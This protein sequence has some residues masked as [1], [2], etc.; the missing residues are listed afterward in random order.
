VSYSAESVAN[1]FLFLSKRDG[2]VVTNMQLQKL[3]Y[4]AH[5]YSLALM[6][7]PLINNDVHAFQYGPVYP[8]LYKKLSLYGS[9]DVRESVKSED[10][11]DP[12]SQEFDLIEAV[13]D[14]YGKMSGAKLS[15]LTH[16]DDTP[17]HKI[18]HTKQFAIIPNDLIKTH[19]QAK[20]AGE[21]NVGE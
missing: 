7:E 17:W 15:T 4:I 19:Y 18:W 13:W 11:I 5:G 16:M 12:S 9:G 10:K 14:M 1:T 8:K 21:A 2:R 3:V 20:V 6:E